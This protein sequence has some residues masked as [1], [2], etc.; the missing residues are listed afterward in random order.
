MRYIKARFTL[1]ITPGSVPYITDFT[2]TGDRTPKIQDITGVSISGGGTIVT[3]PLP[4]HFPPYVQAFNANNTALLLTVTSITT[5]T[6]I[7]HMFN[8][9]GSDV[10]GTINY[11]V[12]GE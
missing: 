10:G 2:P 3:F 1:S 12:T 4:Y 11:R 9:S 8:T 6:F 7:C 5:T